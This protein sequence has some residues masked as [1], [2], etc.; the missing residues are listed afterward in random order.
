MS[1]CYEN[2]SILYTE[3]FFKQLNKTKNKVYEA[4]VINRI[5]TLLN[6]HT[7]KF[8]TQQYVLLTDTKYALTD[9]YFPQLGF[10]VEVDEGHHYDLKL[11]N[12][13]ERGNDFK[14]E[15]K[16]LSQSEKDKIR[17]SHII[18]RTEHELRRINVFKDFESGVTLSLFEI[19]NQIDK[20]VTEIKNKKD[21]LKES[22][23]F[24][25]WNIEKE[26]NPNTYIEQ[27]YLDA[28]NE[29]IFLNADDVC[30]C[31]GAKLNPYK[32]GG[33]KNPKDKETLIWLP[34]LY[35]NDE[36]LNSVSEDGQ[37]IYEKNKYTEK[38]CEMYDVWKKGEQ[39][40]LVF[41]RVR[42]NLTNKGTSLFKFYGLYE[43]HDLSKESGGTWKLVSKR[44]DL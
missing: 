34:K 40:R 7:L 37:F 24:S 26:F 13:V 22:K 5:L 1:N 44:I 25:D 8:V 35:E 30:K 28:S 3:Y 23:K 16:L 6:D 21:N 32:P 12:V 36:W 20:L 31:F 33:V 15:T 38:N 39:K 14:I 42:N 11:A 4:Y 9:L 19:N 41:G 17:Q 10:H 43:L 18:N 29:V 2:K 27:G